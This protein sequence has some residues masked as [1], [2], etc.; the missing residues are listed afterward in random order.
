MGEVH[1]GFPNA[2]FRAHH[3]TDYRQENARP[4]V[5]LGRGLNRGAKGASRLFTFQSAKARGEYRMEG[6]YSPSGLGIG[7]PEQ[8]ALQNGHPPTCRLRR[9]RQ[10]SQSVLGE[11]T[12]PL[13]GSG[14]TGVMLG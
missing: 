14:L 10:P 13:R 2:R 3:G 7:P 9:V 1:E 4:P 12:N 11:P 8:R 5:G 6:D